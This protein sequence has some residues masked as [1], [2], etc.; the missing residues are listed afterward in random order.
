MFL[1]WPAGI[2]QD[3][4]HLFV[5]DAAPYMIKAANSLKALYSKK[6]HVTCLAHVHHTV[7]ETI[8]G[9]IQ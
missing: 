2:R 9:K 5:T 4:V 6:V 8:H 1:L 3:Y 7:A